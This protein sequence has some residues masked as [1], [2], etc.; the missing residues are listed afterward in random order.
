[1]LSQRWKSGG[2]GDTSAAEAPHAG[3]VRSFKIVSVDAA[4]KRIEL[5]LQ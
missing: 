4:A 2:G 1:M 5:E 3:Q